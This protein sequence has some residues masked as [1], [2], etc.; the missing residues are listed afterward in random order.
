MKTIIFI[1]S[2]V[3]LLFSDPIIE[4]PYSRIEN[5][6]NSND[7]AV[8]VSIGK[9][10]ILLKIMDKE[11]GYN[12]TQAELILKTLTVYLV[13]HSK[14]KKAKMVFFVWDCT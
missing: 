14:V 9:E 5:A 7:A 4:V 12:H 2:A 3:A 6:F 11:G 8:I 10:K 13:L 1:L